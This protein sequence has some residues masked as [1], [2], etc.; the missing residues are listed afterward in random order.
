MGQTVTSCPTGVTTYEQ[1]KRIYEQVKPI[2]GLA[3]EVRPLGARRYHQTYSV[4][5][6]EEDGAIE[7]VL[8]QTPVITYLPDN[9]VELRS[10][11]WRSFSTFQF[12]YWT[13]GVKFQVQ[14]GSC[15]MYFRDYKTSQTK[16]L[17]VEFWRD[18]VVRF[19]RDE[20]GNLCYADPVALVYGYRIDRAEANNVRATFKEFA[21][22]LHGFV[23]LRKETLIK[24]WYS[25]AK[26]LE[27]VRFSMDE[28][29]SMFESEKN[30]PFT[31]KRVSIANSVL[32]LIDFMY[33]ANTPKEF[34]GGRSISGEERWARYVQATDYFVNLIRSDQPEETKTANFYKAATILC[35]TVD[36]FRAQPMDD[37]VI[38]AHVNET[39]AAD[40]LKNFIDRKF[41]NRILKRVELAPGVPPN[42]KYEKW[43]NPYQLPASQET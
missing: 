12:I 7:F 30:V 32:D 4:R 20:Y 16:K 19:K 27:V 15:V 29:R 23:S 9:T 22:Y 18:D 24:R 39:Q 37:G 8:Y 43:V 26:E 33:M 1:A 10:G 35:I 28:M 40:R 14:K 41:A 25:T 11:G 34:S 38:E 36:G 3:P 31:V 6:R 13:V 17:V 21:Q 42:S 5:K 2:R